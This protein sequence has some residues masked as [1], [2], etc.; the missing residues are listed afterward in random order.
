MLATDQVRSP[1]SRCGR[2]I[3]RRS[4]YEEHSEGDFAAGDGGLVSGGGGRD[5][6]VVHGG[7]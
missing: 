6:G 3:C 1:A 4:G 2:P 7:G 5:G